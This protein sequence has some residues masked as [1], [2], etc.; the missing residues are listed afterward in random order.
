MKTARLLDRLTGSL[1][2]KDAEI[3]RLAA[4]L[5][6]EPVRISLA[7][8][9]AREEMAADHARAV[10]ALQEQ[11]ALAVG[12]FEARGRTCD[13]LYAEL[14]TLRG[15]LLERTVAEREAKERAE[16]AEAKLAARVQAEI[17]VNRRSSE[18]DQ[19]E[20]DLIALLERHSERMNRKEREAASAILNRKAIVGLLPGNRR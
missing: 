16:R 5:A 14:V 17:D 18:L 13:T 9:R 20:R 10:I 12:A 15:H 3:R 1:R 19:R 2:D 8:Q 11:T 7:V 6:A 4:E